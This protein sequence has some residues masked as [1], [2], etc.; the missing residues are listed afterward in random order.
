MS[1]AAFRV[2]RHFVLLKYYDSKSYTVIT[3]YMF[4]ISIKD[5]KVYY[6]WTKKV[7]DPKV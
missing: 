5:T 7:S 6:I 1:P 4:S 3:E 2:G